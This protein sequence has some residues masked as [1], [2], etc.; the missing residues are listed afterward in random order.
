MYYILQRD[1]SKMNLANANILCVCEEKIMEM[2]TFP[3]TLV[4]FQSI[5]PKE[6]ELTLSATSTLAL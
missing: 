5:L 3:H 2:T 4:L 6:D 1:L